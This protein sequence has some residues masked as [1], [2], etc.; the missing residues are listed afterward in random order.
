METI[1][2]EVLIFK[3]NIHEADVKTVAVVLDADYRI[4]R[5]SVDYGDIDCV[6]RIES[7]QLTTEEVIGRVSNIGFHCEELPD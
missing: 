6:L 1:L 5:W 7:Q 3:T 4:T 2:S